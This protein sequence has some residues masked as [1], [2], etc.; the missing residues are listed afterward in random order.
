VA[1][2]TGK[3]HLLCELG[4]VNIWQR[5]VS[6]NCPVPMLC[7]LNGGIVG[8]IKALTLNHNPNLNLTLIIS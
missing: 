8:E 6:A 4:L 2:S 3:R 7:A 5:K 1:Y